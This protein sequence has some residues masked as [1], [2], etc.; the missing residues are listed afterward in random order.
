MTP[1]SPASQ[2][3]GVTRAEAS[4]QEIRMRAPMSIFPS[5]TVASVGTTR[6]QEM[7]LLPMQTCILPFGK[8]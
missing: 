3:S 8:V 1:R 4:Q 2:Q 5:A 6:D 7:L